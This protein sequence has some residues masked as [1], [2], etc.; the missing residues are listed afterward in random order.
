M[1]K[2]FDRICRSKRIIVLQDVLEPDEMHM[3]STL[4]NDVTLNVRVGKKQGDDIKTEVAITQGDCLSD[5]LFI[6]YIAKSIT[7]NRQC[8]EHI[9]ASIE[10]CENVIPEEKHND[11]YR[12]TEKTCFG[13]TQD[14]QTTPPTGTKRQRQRN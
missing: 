10:Q 1:S 4:V 11:S 13:Q 9:Y 6:L 7:P 3:M 5:V 2:A 8:L 14:K 12:K